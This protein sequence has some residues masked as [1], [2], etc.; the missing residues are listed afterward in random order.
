MYFTITN[1]VLVLSTYHPAYHKVLV[2]GLS[3]NISFILKI[4]R[5]VKGSKDFAC[6]RVDL[7]ELD[8]CIAKI[9]TLLNYCYCFRQIKYRAIQRIRNTYYLHLIDN[10]D[11][12]NREHERKKRHVLLERAAD[13]SSCNTNTLF[14][15][16]RYEEY[17]FRSGT[18][19]PVT[20]GKSGTVQIGNDR[21]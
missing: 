1:I 5:F 11:K 17:V 8:R 12:R 18:N 20:R 16:P 19:G 2:Q 7:T 21:S 3:S 9:G 4:E 10:P 6:L 15:L 13:A 14:A